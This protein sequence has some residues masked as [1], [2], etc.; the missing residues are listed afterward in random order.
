MAS[1][2]LNCTFFSTSNPYPRVLV[3][4][5]AGFI[6]SAFVKKLKTKG[7]QSVKIVDN[8]S[9]SRRSNLIGP[10]GSFVIDEHHG[11]CVA[12]LT[13]AHLSRHV[14]TN[15]DWV[16]HLA[17]SVTGKYKVGHDQV[18]LFRDNVLINSN[19]MRAAS[20]HNVS[21]FVYVGTASSYPQEV[22]E[23]GRVDDPST[24]DEN[25]IFPANPESPYGW[26]KL[27]G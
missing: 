25:Q 7:Y 11:I 9:R 24:V 23:F 3:T 18:G 4:G 1:R 2:A 17:D 5:G 10:T 13:M 6:G 21:K 8:F 19:V 12:D 27:I 16:F 26:S 20:H 15:V 22:N 14:F